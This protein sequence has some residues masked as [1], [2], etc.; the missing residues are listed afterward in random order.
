[1]KYSQL[2]LEQRY[3]IYAIKRA[4][5]K[6]NQIALEI[7]VHPSTVSRELGRNTGKRGYRPKQ[8]HQKAKQRKLSKAHER[9]SPQTWRAVETSLREQ[10]WSPEQISGYLKLHG[11]G[12][13]SA[14]W[15]YQH[16]LA[17]KRAGGSLYLHLRCQKKRKKRYGK[18]SRRGQIPNRRS[19]ELRPTVVAEKTRLG[20]WEADTI[21][22]KN[23]QQAIVSLVERKTKFCLLAKLEQKTAALL[24]Q[25]ACGKLAAH[26]AKVQTITSDNGREACQSSANCRIFGGRFFLCQSV[27]LMGTR[28]E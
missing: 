15:I 25:A 14:E 27:S 13:V 2:T 18:T 16:I 24:E 28:I 21:I 11:L 8:A 7:S 5:F 12:Q 19:I 17:D 22:G 26:K 1:M 23:H 3:Q 10:Q 6:Q 20:D 9:V 4:G